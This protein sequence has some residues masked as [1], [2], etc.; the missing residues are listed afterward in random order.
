[1]RTINSNKD[2]KRMVSTSLFRVVRE[3]EKAVA[4]AITG[5]SRG[6]RKDGM[7]WIPK[8]MIVDG[9]VP[10]WKIT[11]SLYDAAD[12]GIENAWMISDRTGNAMDVDEMA[13]IN[14]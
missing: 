4:Y 5:E 10:A 11:R 8:S 9:C 3:S 7:I 13:E 12:W 1:M 2:E 14:Y 6:K